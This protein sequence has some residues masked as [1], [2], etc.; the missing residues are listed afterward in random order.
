MSGQNHGDRKNGGCQ[1][2]GGGEMR[3]SCLM[4]IGFQFCKMKKVL[5]WTVVIVAQ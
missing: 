4:D 2:L 3:I 5:Q 1:G